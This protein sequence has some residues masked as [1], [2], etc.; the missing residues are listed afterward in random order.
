MPW[1]VAWAPTP[2]NGR[3]GCIYS[4][5]HKTS[6]WRKV[7]L[8]AAPQT[9]RWCTGRCTFR[10]SVR[11]AVDLTPQAT[12]GT[13]AFYTGHF[14]CHTGQSGGLLST[15]PPGTSHWGYCSWCTGQSSALDHI[16][17]KQHFFL[18]LGLHL[19]FIM[20]SFEVFLFSMPWSK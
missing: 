19:I 15:V 13:Q 18:F 1:Y 2:W 16:V 3:L 10:C 8:S 17:R 14:G 6:C 12:V 9:V 5:Q 4:P 7:V 20:S 11:L